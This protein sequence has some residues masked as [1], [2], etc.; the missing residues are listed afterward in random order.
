MKFSLRKIKH[1]LPNWEL[2]VVLL[3]ALTSVLIAARNVVYFDPATSTLFSIQLASWMCVSGV[4]LVA[5]RL[6]DR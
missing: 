4:Y 6:R 1:Q 5:Y 3:S 2:A